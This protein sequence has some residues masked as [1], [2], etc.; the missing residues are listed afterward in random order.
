MIPIFNTTYKIKITGQ[1]IHVRFTSQIGPIPKS[2]NC[3]RYVPDNE[4]K[5]DI[6][7]CTTLNKGGNF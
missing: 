7:G 5:G 6:L 2:R 4:T 1:K 3:F